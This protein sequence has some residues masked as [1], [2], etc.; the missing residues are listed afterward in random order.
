M[1]YTKIPRKLIYKDRRWLEDFG[2]YNEHSINKAVV[3]KMK[4]Y[5]GDFCEERH[6]LTCLNNA[7]HICTMVLLEKDPVLRLNEY[8]K[9]AREYQHGI[10][11]SA[12]MSFVYYYLCLLPKG[13]GHHLKYFLK[14]LRN[15]V[16]IVDERL[17]EGLPNLELPANEFAPRV[18][19][20]SAVHDVEKSG[21]SWKVISDYYENEYLSR[22]IETLGK[23]I[24]EKLQLIEMFKT[25]IKNDYSDGSIYKEE[26]IEYLEKLRN[27]IAPDMEE[28]EHEVSPNDNDTSVLRA[29]IAELE[30]EVGDL[31][32]K[33]SEAD[34]ADIDE[35]FPDQSSQ[36]KTSDIDVEKLSDALKKIEEQAQ[37][38]Q[39]Q[40]AEIAR[41]NTLNEVI[42][43]QLKRYQD[44][45]ASTE[46]LDEKKKLEIDERIIFVSALLG[47]SLKPDVVNQTQL[48]KLIE[49]LTGDAWQSIRPRISS[50]NSET[51]QVI[52][53][54][55]KQFSEGTQSAAK[56]VYE[57]I[58]KAVKGATRENKGYQCKQ[59]MEN[60]NQTYH[61][62]IKM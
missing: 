20:E 10:V 17:L 2:I 55:I 28:I 33:L 45:E 41:L 40:K 7:Y 48:A 36:N 12:T 29:R 39:E 61:L 14:E 1:D 42:D 19:D 56:N 59:A 31:K 18:I 47:V 3:E 32:N 43:K 50:I 51:Q 53:K 8:C 25:A 21:F 9:E 62:S 34:H 4:M 44:E 35:I 26:K 11:D 38:I 52:D 46:T 5:L 30:K 22:V 16:Q 23:N 49:K 54:T 6:I 60:I 57:L 15:R 58:N 37:T 13:V 24:P 27:E